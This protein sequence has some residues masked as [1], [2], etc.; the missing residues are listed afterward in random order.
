MDGLIA[1]LVIVVLALVGGSLAGWAALSRTGDLRR[2]LAAA[3]AA[4]AALQAA[5]ASP[6]AA[7]APVE[8]PA[9]E[10]IPDV[11]TSP[12][13]A[14]D[15]APASAE[16]ADLGPASD[17][18]AASAAGDAA[19]PPIIR[20][21]RR[22]D[23]EE[24][25]G[26]RWAVWVGGIALALGGVFLVRYS[27][28]AGLIGPGLRILLGLLFAGVLL[29]A[30]EMLRRRDGAEPP[31]ALRAAYVPGVLTAAGT[32]SAFAAIYAA[33]A[34][35]G[36]LGDAAA[37]LAL[38]AVALATLALSLLHGP[39]LAGL[40]LAAGYL[41]PVLVSSE[42]PAFG[43]LVLYLLVL[44][45]ATLAVARLRGWRWLAIS[46][47]VGQI[48]WAAVMT[49]ASTRPGY[50]SVVVA[51]HVLLSY[52]LTA[53]TFAA[54]I[55][56]RAPG[57]ETPHDRAG[58]VMLAL[59]CIPVI[60]HVAGF[61]DTAA[62]V[63]LV[64]GVG[65]ALTV[66]AYEWPA[67]RLAALAAI[68]TVV[69]G[70]AGLA[71]PVIRPG[72]ET[73]MIDGLPAVDA[74]R[75]IGSSLAAGLL[76]GGLGLFGVA[77][78]ASRVVQAVV[79]TAVPLGV[80]V[81]AYLRLTE[82]TQSLP[83]ATLALVLAAYFGVVTE[84]LSRRLPRT[85]FG[86]D[87]A[88]AT[89]AIAAVAA[90][91]CGLTAALEK[92]FLT[93]ALALLVPAIAWVEAARPVPGLRAVALA[94]AAVVV[95]RFVTGPAVVGADVGTTPVFNWLL[96]GY[97]APALAFAYGA[98]R[99]GHTRMD[100]AV[101]VFEA[102]AVT[103]TALTLVMVIHHGMTG[104]DLTAPISGLAEQSL[105]TLSLLSVSLG[106][107][108][109]AVRRPG[110]VFGRGTLVVGGLGLLFGG[111]GLLVAQNPLVTGEPVTGGAFSGVLAL[112][113]LLPSLMAFAVAIVARRRPDR[114][115]WY[116]ASAGWLGGVLAV[117]W[118][119]LAVRAGFHSGDLTVGPVEESELYAY[120]VVWLLAGLLVL[121]T[122]VA[123]GARSVRAVAAALIAAV[124]VK[125]FLVDTSGLSGVW[126]AASFMGTGAV[127]ILIGFA[128]QRLA[129]RLGPAT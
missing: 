71:T 62:G 82:F 53:A 55:H 5:A 21:P 86:A 102:L 87:G 114:P 44:T 34:L 56:P 23:L 27:I 19:P 17:A 33:Y 75:L 121:A 95:A 4:L 1:I 16:S 66:T 115:R 118:V 93:V 106:M 32:V 99:F 101:P 29:A 46:A 61:G 73:A 50:D 76:F 54:S 43:S 60:L 80:G 113:Y 39:G 12:E 8:N 129:R 78:S 36:F 31:A 28:E 68:P 64:F 100:P 116:V 3:E 112:G 94:V 117:A 83:F 47:V 30:G 14:P 45:V 11:G 52:G 120:S 65:A 109:L 15:A 9:P 110:L 74:G 77:G 96:Y 48:G 127:L 124:V 128:Y 42:A 59:F 38:G 97:G 10:P 63:G 90:I 119:T 20:P 70:L 105:L 13:P 125:V 2:R 18:D 41:A 84:T 24:A 7:P 35:Y 103:F 69:I 85:W 126:R 107:Q 57:R 92:G 25:L 26:T 88:T 6:H 22:R 40:G 49:A 108:W 51:V 67:V 111:L 89:Y 104:G 123:I 79:G 98:W 122:G 81:M 58:A 91:G 72:L 37:F